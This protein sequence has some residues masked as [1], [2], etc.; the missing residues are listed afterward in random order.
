[1]RDNFHP[2]WK[3]AMDYSPQDVMNWY[4]YRQDKGGG[5][6]EAESLCQ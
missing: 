6:L 1:M 5:I 3:F 4:F 2:K